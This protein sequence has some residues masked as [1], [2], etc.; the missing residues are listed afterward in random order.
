MGFTALLTVNI[1]YLTGDDEAM[2]FS[3]TPEAA[4]IPLERGGGLGSVSGRFCRSIG[5]RRVIEKN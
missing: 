1:L 2:S 5:K 3:P 4:T